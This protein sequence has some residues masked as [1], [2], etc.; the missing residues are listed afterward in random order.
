MKKFVFNFFFKCLL[1]DIE[2]SARQSFI[3]TNNIVRELPNV[4]ASS[5]PLCGLI[6]RYF[7]SL[8]NVTQKELRRG[9]R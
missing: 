7:L 5:V 1:H 8:F 9:I 3:R 6:M 2:W 4:E